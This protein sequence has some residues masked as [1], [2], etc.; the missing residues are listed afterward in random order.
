MQGRFHRVSQQI[1]HRF[2][3]VASGTAPIEI[4]AQ[5]STNKYAKGGLATLSATVKV[6]SSPTHSVRLPSTSKALNMMRGCASLLNCHSR[7][8]WLRPTYCTFPACTCSSTCVALLPARSKM[9][10]SS[11]HMMKSAADLPFQQAKAAAH[12]LHLP[13]MHLQ[14]HLR[15]PPP[16]SSM[17]ESHQVTS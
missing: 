3:A 15:H 9:D 8:P 14:F 7:K 6:T 2:E 1:R 17:T 5:D 10:I 12:I 11:D 16:A 4:C 13:R